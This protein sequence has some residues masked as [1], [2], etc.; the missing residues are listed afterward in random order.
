MEFKPE[1]RWYYF[2]QQQPDEVILIRVHDSANDG[3]ARLSFHTS[4]ENPL[5][6]PDEAHEI[7]A[8]LD[9]RPPTLVAVLKPDHVRDVD[10]FA[11]RYGARAFGPWLFWRGNG[12]FTKQL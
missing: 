4:F 8:R 11:R 5:A 7:W 9:A 12:L 6:P 3:R 1:H 2:S 10:L